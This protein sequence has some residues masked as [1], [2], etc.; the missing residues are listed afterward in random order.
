MQQQLMELQDKYKQAE[1]LREY[2][3][4]KREVT[5]SRQSADDPMMVEDVNIEGE[6]LRTR[7]R[8]ASD[9]KAEEQ[10][11]RKFEADLENLY[12]QI[13]HR[14][15]QIGVQREHNALMR[16]RGGSGIDGL[17]GGD[18]SADSSPETVLA[19]ALLGSLQLGKTQTD[20]APLMA[21]YRILAEDAVQRAIVAG[22]DIPAQ[23]RF[24]FARRLFLSS[25]AEL[26]TY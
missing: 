7:A 25:I 5:G 8:S 1:E 26:E 3:R 16:E 12:S 9:I 18:G 23:N 2:E 20:N 22:R 17:V 19:D 21:Q 4:K 6:V 15:D 14:K 13:Q 11:D 24:K 10:S